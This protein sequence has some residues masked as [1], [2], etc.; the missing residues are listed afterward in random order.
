MLIGAHLD[1]VDQPSEESY[2]KL[3]LMHARVV[4]TLWTNGTRHRRD[5]Y[6]RIEVLL[7]RPIYIVR[8]G[9]SGKTTASQ[10]LT[11]AR[12]AFAEIPLDAIA[13]RRVRWRVLNEVNLPDEGGWTPAEYAALLVEVAARWPQECGDLVA[14]PISL[15]PADAVTWWNAFVFACLGRIPAKRVAVNCYAHLVAQA[16]RFTQVKRPVDVTEINTLAIAPGLE[17]A[18]WLVDRFRELA[19]AGIQSAQVFITG[20]R[21]NGAWDERYVLT[22]E[23]AEEIGRLTGGEIR[24]SEQLRF[25]DI[26][27]NNGHVDLAAVKAAGYDGVILKI[28]EDDF[29][30]DDYFDTY[31]AENL[32]NAREL[33]LLVGVYTFL[34]PSKSSPA[35]S[36]GLLERALRRLGGLRRGEVIA[37]DN[38]DPLYE[39]DQHVWLAEA[40]ALGADVFWFLLWKYSADYYTSSRNLEHEDLARYPTWWAAYQDKLPQPQVGWGPIRMWQHAVLPAGSVPGVVGECDVNIFYGSREDFLALGAP[41]NWPASDSSTASEADSPANDAAPPEWESEG[42]API[43]QGAHWVEQRADATDADR[44]AAAEIIR[45]M[46]EIKARHLVRS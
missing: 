31:A 12:E 9:P 46:D 35:E 25:V 3:E 34:R 29:G 38:E 8:V 10:W 39:G 27:N 41:A 32:A 42:C 18:R 16:S 15:G 40:L 45:L 30:L 19:R 26:S 2:R 43:Y 17:R 13:E 4:G 33:D 23:E 1:N 44:A 21:S 11:D 24:V 28:S 7:E 5:V 20:G 6:Q 36:I 14:A 22:Q 37:L